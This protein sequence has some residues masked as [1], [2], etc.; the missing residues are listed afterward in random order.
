MLRFTLR[1]LLVAIP[2]LLV[3]IAAAFF[4]MRAAPGGPFD[5]EAD[6]EPEVLQNIRA[7][8]D[9]DKPLTTQFV[10]FL[11]RAAR[12]D[13]GPSLVYRDFSVTELISIGLPVSAKLGLTAMLVA[14]LIGGLG[15]IFAA[16]RQNSLLDHAL[17][18]LA[19][20]G[21]ALPA[22]VSAPIMALF[23]GLYL[24]WLPVAG[25][26]DGAAANMVLPVIA[27]ALPQIAIIARLMRGGML[28]V[29]RS[30]FVRTA[31]SRGLRESRIVFRHVLPSGIVPL[32]G[33][34]GPALAGIMTGSLIVEMIFNLPGVGRYFVQGALNRDYPL[35]MGIVIIYASFII[36]LNLLS[37]LAYAA[38]DPRVR[39][40]Y[41]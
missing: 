37:D 4:L 31:R 6:L 2:T 32:V 14:L 17:M 27:I 3:I 13:F 30:N 34:L 35:V 21:I 16:L 25:W 20:T 15:G 7:A 38:L 1:R 10:L 36:L 12:G 40:G 28:E 41:R 23:F 9:L 5:T 22:F 24:K 26:N 11:S 8:Y 33:Y 39:Q 18:A 19:M 29:L